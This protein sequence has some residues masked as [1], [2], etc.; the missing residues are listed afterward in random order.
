MYK[1]IFMLSALLCA[2]HSFAHDG[3]VSMHHWL[4]MHNGDIVILLLIIVSLWF[5]K[6]SL[7]KK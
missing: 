2:N 5:L 1:L 4:H 6:R 3:L 7:L